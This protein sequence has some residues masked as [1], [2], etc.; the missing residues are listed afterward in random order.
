[1]VTSNIKK[2]KLEGE[3]W[4][5]FKDILKYDDKFISILEWITKRQ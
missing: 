2:R 5:L 3:Y 4:I 1:M